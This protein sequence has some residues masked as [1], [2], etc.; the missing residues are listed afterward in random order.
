MAMQVSVWPVFLQGTESETSLLVAWPTCPVT[1][2][3]AGLQRITWIQKWI[4]AMSLSRYSTYY[5]YI[6]TMDWMCPPRFVC[7]SPNSLWGKMVFGDGAFER[8]FGSR[9]GGALMMELISVRRGHKISIHHVKTQQG[10]SCLQSKKALTRTQP[11]CHP[12]LRLPASK[13]VRYRSL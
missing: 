2:Y 6:H 1:L 12:D 7:W 9:A 3:I 10:G 11:C 4:T 13:A 5:I 8:S